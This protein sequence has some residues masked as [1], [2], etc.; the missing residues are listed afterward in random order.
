MLLGGAAMG[1][2]RLH[3]LDRPGWHYLWLSLAPQAL[4]IA[5]GSSDFTLRGGDLTFALNGGLL[6]LFGLVWWLVG[7]VYLLLAAGTDGPN[8]YGY[9]P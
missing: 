9:P 3:D 1:V 5:A 4:A 2:K 8:K 6:T 7:L